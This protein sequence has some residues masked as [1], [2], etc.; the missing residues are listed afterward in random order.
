M[1]QRDINLLHD[2][3]DSIS[4]INTYVEKGP[5]QDPLI[6]DAVRM[7]IIEIGIAVKKLSKDRLSREPQIPWS[8]ISGMRDH[9]AHSYQDTNVHLVI[10]VIDKHLGPLKEAVI[11]L[12]E[13]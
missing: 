13:G 1:T 11:R 6:Y 5:M 7:R 4:A 10:D 3:L 12:I 9:L 2:I 8:N